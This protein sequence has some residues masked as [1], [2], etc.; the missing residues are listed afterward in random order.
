MGGYGSGRWGT[1]K[2]GANI[3]V[4]SCPSLDINRPVREGVV[5]PDAHHRASWEW[6]GENRE[7]VCTSSGLVI[8]TE[9]DSG[10][11]RLLYSVG[12]AGEEQQVQDY[13]IPLVTTVL[14]F[15]GRRWW[16]RCVANRNGGPPCRR[17]VGVLYLPPGRAG[18]RVPPLL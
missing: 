1:G 5:C 6:L 8:R 13:P 17:R 11:I 2:A 7:E 18:L 14:A 15:G 12:R 9:V 10:T 16:F 4:E 3:L